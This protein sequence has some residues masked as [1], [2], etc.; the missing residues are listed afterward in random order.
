MGPCPSWIFILYPDGKVTYHGREH[1]DRTGNYSGKISTDRL[2]EFKSMLDKASFFDFKEVYYENVTDLPTT[3]LFYKN[4]E[5][6]LKIMDY[7]GAPKTLKSLEFKIEEFI[8][9]IDW[10]KT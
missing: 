7:Y 5:N 9:T 6:S 8:E 1:V 10:K 3:Y 2:N 4:G